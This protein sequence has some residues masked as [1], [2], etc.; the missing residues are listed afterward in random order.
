M[1]S[2]SLLT[3]VPSPTTRSTHPHL[4]LSPR[5][6][7][8]NLY[9]STTNYDPKRHQPLHSSPTSPLN[10]PSL[11]H[12]VFCRLT[13]L[14]FHPG[15][16]RQHLHNE[17]ILISPPSS[18]FFTSNQTE[19][20]PCLQA[21]PPASQEARAAKA[22]PSLQSANHLGQSHVGAE[23]IASAASSRVQ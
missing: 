21:Q 11:A 18:T 23:M 10:T 20:T 19:R 8:G 6:S 15:Y 9:P 12:L 17:H 4:G 5:Q 7:T 13:H 22:R 2:A 14:Y 16:I 3:I 1:C